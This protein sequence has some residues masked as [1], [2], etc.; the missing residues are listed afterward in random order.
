M[1]RHKDDQPEPKPCATCGTC[2]TCGHRPG[3]TITIR[4]WPYPYVYPPTTP[5]WYGTSVAAGSTSAVS[6]SLN[7]TN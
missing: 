2:P 3:N 4:T 1:T 6:Y 7:A 5:Y